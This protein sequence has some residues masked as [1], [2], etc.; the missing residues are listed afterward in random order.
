MSA[1]PGQRPATILVAD[2]DPGVVAALTLLF[3]NE[4][5]RS[6]TVDDPGKVI[7]TLAELDVSAVVMDLNYSLDTT[8]GEEGLALIEA[9]RRQDENL[10]IIVMTGWGTI[11]LAVRSMQR[12]ADDFVQKPWDNDRMLAS[13]TNQLR[14]ASAVRTSERLAGQNRILRQE[15]DRHDEVIAE[16][17]VM[18]E[19][20]ET[21]T[22]V[23]RSDVGVLLTGESGTGK[24]LL[25]RHIHRRSA[26]A[27]GP[28]IAVN[29]GA[30]TE[31]LFESEM[32]GHAKGAFTDARET[33]IG[34]LELADGGTLFLD[35]IANAPVSQQAKLLR[36]LEDRQFEKVGARKTQS[37]DFRLVSATNSDLERAVAEG[38]FRADL[39]YRVNAV[40]IQVPPLRRRPEDILPLARRFLARVAQRHGGR[41][42][43]LSPAAAAA[44]THYDWPGNVRELHHVVER[45]QLLCRADV[46]EAGDLGLPGGPA[47]PE[48]RREEQP[49]GAQATLAEIEARALEARLGHYSG[50]AAAA[51]ESLGLSRSAFYRR[52]AKARRHR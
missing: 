49:S 26:R 23:A 46:V 20:L 35:E 36:A 13:V 11:D 6:V 25:A 41:A 16:S 22:Q 10:P 42:P 21:L 38:R 37:S 32:F 30:I 15:L 47:Q 3:S 48:P 1:P 29:L 33:R 14:R 7:D 12:G 17:P 39:L 19:L 51:A 2:D 43:G 27:E 40:E 5:L 4:G 45:A 8:S 18:R 44:L 31:S 34:R 50:D 24:S 28:F 9:I 52:L